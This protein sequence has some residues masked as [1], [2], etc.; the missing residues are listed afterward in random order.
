[1]PESSHTIRWE[2][3]LHE[4]GAR[5]WS[6]RRIDAG[7]AIEQCSEGY[8]DF[9]QAVADAV[10]H[11]FRPKECHWLIKSATWTHHFAPGGAPVTVGPD[12]RPAGRTKEESD[13]APAEEA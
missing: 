2:L 3:V 13:N 5:T 9:G 7:G 8:A 12:A 11:G 1:M 4:N 6:W 10:N